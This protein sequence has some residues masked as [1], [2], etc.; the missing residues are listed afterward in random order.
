MIGCHTVRSWS[1]TQA[2]VTL[3]SAEAELHAAVKTTA[4]TMGMMSMLKDMGVEM[5][6]KAI[7][8]ADAAAALGIIQRK[9]VGKVRHLDTS[10][11]WLQEERVKRIL[12]HE[13]VLGEQNP[14]D[15]MTKHI[16]REKIAQHVERMML[17]FAKGRAAKAP[18]TK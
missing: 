1:K 17:K 4:E 7:V 11:L 9:G 13:K 14:A 2:T 15:M 3:S 12:A 6:K 8:Y 10:V 16:P 5:T 18:K